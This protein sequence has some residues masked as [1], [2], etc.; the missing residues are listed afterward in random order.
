MWM[1]DEW[2]YLVVE[3]RFG[4]ALMTVENSASQIRPEDL[5]EPPP[6]TM[7]GVVL[8]PKDTQELL[9][10]LEGVQRLTLL[11]GYTA[12][13]VWLYRRDSY[14]RAQIDIGFYRRTRVYTKEAPPS[15]PL[16]SNPHGVDAL[17]AD[18]GLDWMGSAPA[19]VVIPQ[20][21]ISPFWPSFQ[22]QPTPV[23]STG[24][25]GA[26]PD[27]KFVAL[28]LPL[29]ANQLGQRHPRGSQ[30]RR[31]LHGHSAQEC[32]GGGWRR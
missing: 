20:L 14:E 32:L 10:A 24:M 29:T 13:H 19:M 12:R 8:G 27:G 9:R 5:P 30:F 7:N 16:A 17:K 23:M 11:S 22:M 15:D 31:K 26:M 25:A 6:V 18:H 1:G 2:P 28:A 4:C 3:T 21:S